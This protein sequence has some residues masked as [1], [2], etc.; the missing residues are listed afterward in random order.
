MN[1]VTELIG[2]KNLTEEEVISL[3]NEFSDKDS[4]VVDYE[5]TLENTLK[6]GGAKPKDWEVTDVNF[7]NSPELVGK[8]RILTK[9]FL[10]D[11]G[12]NSDFTIKRMKNCGYRPA[13][14]ME[15][16]SL[17][18]GLSKYQKQFQIFA[19]G[20]PFKTGS[21]NQVIPFISPKGAGVS[22]CSYP[23]IKCDRLLG[24][25]EE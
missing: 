24:V 7:P 1:N 5:K 18:V 12:C 4:V 11:T 6:L 13:T 22:R 15:L 16:A 17:Y 25:L 21:G 10:P 3:I 14:I 8:V 20:S 23:E 9:L 19:F 2:K